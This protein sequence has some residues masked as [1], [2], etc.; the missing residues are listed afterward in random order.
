MAKKPA[1]Y[2]RRFRQLVRQ[3][4]DARIASR[5]AGFAG[6]YEVGQVL[7]KIRML[8]T[9]RDYQSTKLIEA[10]IMRTEKP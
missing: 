10:I 4:M 6:D 3:D 7:A 8:P 2:A 5:N 1:G 9:L